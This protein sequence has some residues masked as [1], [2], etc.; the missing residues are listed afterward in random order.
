MTFA[1]WVTG[2]IGLRRGALYVV[3]QLAGA[4]AGCAL[5]SAILPAATPERLGAPMLGAG[6]DATQGFVVETILSFAL[7]STIFMSALHPHGDGNLAPLA[8]G[9]VMVVGYL[10]GGPL[11]GPALNPARSFGIAVVTGVWSN[12]WVYWMGPLLGGTLAAVITN[13]IFL[14]SQ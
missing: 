5:L 6:I 8:I 9:L 2:R 4:T 13:Q 11:T 3:M 12:H 14:K 7:V 1:A 10:A